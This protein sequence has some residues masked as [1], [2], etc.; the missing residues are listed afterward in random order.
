M[1]FIHLLARG[2]PAQFPAQK[3]P[4]DNMRAPR[5]CSRG[6]CPAI[7]ELYNGY[8]AHCSIWIHTADGGN[9]N[10]S[11]TRGV[12]AL[13]SSTVKYGGSPRAT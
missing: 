2:L 5:L 6:L 8:D 10:S 1:R 7:A 12:C 9:G 13:Y 11:L 3:D 4:H